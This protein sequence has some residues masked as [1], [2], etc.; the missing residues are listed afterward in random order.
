MK[1]ALLF[2]GGRNVRENKP[3]Y[4]NDLA[5]FYKTLVEIYQYPKEEIVVCF[6]DG[7]DHDFDGDGKTELHTRASQQ[8]LLEHLAWLATSTK[9]D[10][11]VFVATN[12][13]DPEGL[14]LWGEDALITPQ[15]MT[16]AFS[17][18]E[19]TKIFI[20][21]QCY[22]GVFGYGLALSDSIVCCACSELE[23][24]LPIPYRGKEVPL[25][26]EF[27]YQ[28]VG[29]LSGQYPDGS[30]LTSELLSSKARTLYEAFNYA[31]RKDRNMKTPLFFPENQAWATQ[32]QL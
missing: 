24:S 15:Q 5:A 22:A 25:Y 1:K 12:H 23:E 21:G 10:T 30:A 32:I 11:I 4:R 16:D 29:A 3:R 14:C 7:G 31:R 2:S 27:L 6:A 28:M 17:S 19:A 13:G 20:F 26:D 9:E 8:Q 18:C